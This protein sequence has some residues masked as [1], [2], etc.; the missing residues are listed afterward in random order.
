MV[1]HIRQTHAGGGLACG[2]AQGARHAKHAFT[3]VHGGLDVLAVTVVGGRHLEVG[4]LGL[5]GIA[6]QIIEDVIRGGAPCTHRH[7]ARG[8]DHRTAVD[9]GSQAVAQVI[10]DKSTHQLPCGI[11]IGLN[12]CHRACT[13]DALT[14]QC[15]HRNVA[16]LRHAATAER[17]RGAAFQVHHRHHC[18]HAR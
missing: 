11:G 16:H 8:T 4:D 10:D 14:R 2:Q 3:G 5:F 15:G 1:L 18:A 17:G 6:Q 9:A 7:V 13:N 12:A